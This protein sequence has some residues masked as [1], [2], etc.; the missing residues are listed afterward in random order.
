MQSC[1]V[2]DICYHLVVQEHE[3]I[4]TERQYARAQH[5]PLTEQEAEHEKRDKSP[6]HHAEKLTSDY[7]RNSLDQWRILFYFKDI[8]VGVHRQSLL[9]CLTCCSVCIGNS[10]QKNARGSNP[11]KHLPATQVARLCY[12]HLTKG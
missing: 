10:I 7:I 8:F 5:I 1:K 11:R 9:T 2:C 12:A 4:E 6:S 3:L